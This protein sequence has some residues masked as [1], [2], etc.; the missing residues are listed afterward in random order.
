MNNTV[1][2][3]AP[4]VG[5]P[6]KQQEHFNAA[7]RKALNQS[8]F[9]RFTITTTLTASA[10]NIWSAT[11]PLNSTWDVEMIIVGHATDGSAAGYRRVTRFHRAT[12][13]ATLMGTDALGTDREDVV[14]WGVTVSASATDAVLQVTGDA[15]RTVSWTA[16]VRIVEVKL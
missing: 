2:E 15:A 1:R 10:T 9:E 16:L 8:Y 5:D 12:G 13:N 11:L 4:T 14:G 7:V 6:E 3:V